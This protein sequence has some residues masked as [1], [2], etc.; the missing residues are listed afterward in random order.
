MYYKMSV[1]SLSHVEE[2]HDSGREEHHDREEHEYEE[3]KRC[4]RCRR[5]S[6]R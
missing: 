5:P 4:R 6:K 2:E 3:H 1:I